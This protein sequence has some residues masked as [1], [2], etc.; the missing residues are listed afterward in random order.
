LLFLIIS[1]K[2]ENGFTV[3]DLADIYGPAE[4]YVGEFNKGVL[5]FFNYLVLFICFYSQKSIN[6]KNIYI[7]KKKKIINKQIKGV[8]SSPRSKDCLFFTKF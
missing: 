5:L 3:F 7:K 8:L 1:Q 4:L 6:K 2:T